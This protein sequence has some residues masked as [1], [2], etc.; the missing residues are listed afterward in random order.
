MKFKIESSALYHNLNFFPSRHKK[1]WIPTLIGFAGIMLSVMAWFFINQHR[2][3]VLRNSITNETF[4]MANLIEQNMGSRFLALDR[5]TN[6]WKVSGGTPKEEWIVDARNQY[7]DQPGY[8]AIEWVDST[9]HI[10]WIVPFEGNE[11]AQDLNLKEHKITQLGDKNKVEV[12]IISPIDLVQ[13]E[14]GFVV[15]NPIQIDGTFEGLITGVFRFQTWLESI[16]KEQVSKRFAV[17]LMYGNTY[18]AGVEDEHV[19]YNLEYAQNRIINYAGVNWR[20]VLTPSE[21]YV[22]TELGAVPYLTLI[23]GTCLSILLAFSTY[24]SIIANSTKRSLRD[25]N[26]VLN[27]KTLEL[28]TNNLELEQFA[29]VASHDLQEPLRTVT[30]FVELLNIDYKDKLEENGEKYLRFISQ[31]STRMSALIKSLL[32]YSRIGKYRQRSSVD[33][34]II[35][36]EV[37]DDLGASIKEMKASIHIDEMPVLKGFETELR[38]LFQNMITNAIKFRK[39][40]TSPSIRISAKKETGWWIFSIQDNGIGI[41]EAHKEKI[42]VIFQRLHARDEYEGTGIGLAHCRKIVE[43]HGGKIW[44]TSKLN[45][46]STFYFTIPI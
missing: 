6:R 34:N 4:G 29:Y 9:F 31:A 12:T 30:S 5:M 36:K 37:C 44:V 38:M 40:E 19:D 42:F 41:E 14:K 27:K 10:R 2:C 24:T 18:L 22:N 43:L 15:Y 45:E 35:L 1:Y 13:G 17:H 26:D 25:T 21:S 39:K 3:S 23:L 16:L 7:Q 20:L 46:G 32:D 33:C 28:E 8:Q 11:Q